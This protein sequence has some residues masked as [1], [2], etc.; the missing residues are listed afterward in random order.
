MD[1]HCNDA[2]RYGFDT[3]R[4]IGQ[5]RIVK[6]RPLEKSLAR[7]VLEAV[8]KIPVIVLIRFGMNDYGVCYIGRLDERRIICQRLRRWTIRRVRVIRESL[9]LEQMYVC[10]DDWRRSVWT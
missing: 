8:V 10:I 2:I 4:C 7:F 9:W 1:S 5:I 3:C 6:A